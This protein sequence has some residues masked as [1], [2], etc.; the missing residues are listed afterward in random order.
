LVAAAVLLDCSGILAMGV[1]ASRAVEIAR[2][3]GSGTAFP[4]QLTAVY[5]SWAPSPLASS[6]PISTG[7]EHGVRH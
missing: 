6:G 3:S 1:V 4:G 2:V 7:S 5:S